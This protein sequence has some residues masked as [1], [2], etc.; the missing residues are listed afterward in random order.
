MIAALRMSG[1]RIVIGSRQV[2]YI[3]LAT[4]SATMIRRVV[5]LLNERHRRVGSILGGG[6]AVQQVAYRC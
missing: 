6:I 2:G 5:F 4:L 3:M 1:L